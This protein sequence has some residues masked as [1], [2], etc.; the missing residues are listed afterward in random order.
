MEKKFEIELFRKGVTVGDCTILLAGSQILTYK[1]E[2][3]IKA[4][5]IKNINLAEDEFNNYLKEMRKAYQNYIIKKFKRNKN[6]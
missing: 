5:D 3:L 2:Q 4:I 6:D 1:N